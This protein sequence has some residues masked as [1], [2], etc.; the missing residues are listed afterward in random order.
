LQRIAS[1]KF[2]ANVPSIDFKGESFVV[3]SSAPLYRTKRGKYIYLFEKG[4]G[5]VLLKTSDA[6]MSPQLVRAV[7]KQEIVKQ[8]VAGLD[9]GM[10]LTISQIMFAIMGALGGMGLGWILC[11]QFG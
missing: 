3:D 5:Q 7:F 8:L 10:S 4:K 11:A 9:S 6:I 1:K 2:R